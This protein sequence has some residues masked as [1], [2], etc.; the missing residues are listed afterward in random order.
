MRFKGRAW[1]SQD[2]S[3]AVDATGR[4]AFNCPEDGAGAPPMCRKERDTFVSLAPA[5]PQAF[6][7]FLSLYL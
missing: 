2:A 4:R 5:V 7:P 6:A 1:A 3:H